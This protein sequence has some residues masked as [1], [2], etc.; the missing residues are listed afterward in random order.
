MVFKLE[1]KDF[2]MQPC[3]SRLAF[4]FVPKK[5][6]FLE[7]HKVTEGLKQ[8]GVLVEAVTPFLIMGR[9]KG[10]GISIFKSGKIIIKDTN[11]EDEARK[12]AEWL[13]SKM[14]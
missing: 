2:V 12:T 4:E 5:K 6:Q 1:L 8:S 14:G 10:S 7:L 3:K 13:I 9:C 11:I